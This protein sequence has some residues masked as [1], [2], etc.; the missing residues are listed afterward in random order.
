MDV[1]QQESEWSF[2]FVGVMSTPLNN[3][4]DDRDELTVKSIKWVSRVGKI[5]V[6]QYEP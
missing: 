1:W 5:V 2:P 6:D 3:N 4:C